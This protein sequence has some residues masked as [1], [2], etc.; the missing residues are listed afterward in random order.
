MRYWVWPVDADNWKIV[1][2]KKVWATRSKSAPEKVKE[3]DHIAF[4]LVG[5]GSFCG[6]CEVASK[7]YTNTELFWADEPSGGPKIYPNE[8]KLRIVQQGDA[9][10]SELVPKLSFVTN[11]SVYGSYLRAHAGGPGNFGKPMAAE[12]YEL[13]FDALKKPASSSEAKTVEAEPEEHEEIVEKILELGALMG[14][15][16]SG[17][18]ED[19][20]V[21]TGA[22][23]DAV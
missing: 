5:H 19:T 18:E 7:W 14:F 12:D 3:G 6:V 15:E 13:I 16:A 4:Y 1:T 23:L 17:D 8:C 10:Y 2:E 22:V 11:K 9:S 20:K 21:A